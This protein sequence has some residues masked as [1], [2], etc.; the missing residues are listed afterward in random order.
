MAQQVPHAQQQQIS[1][2]VYQQAS[3]YQLGAPT[4]TYDVRYTTKAVTGSIAGF[5]L[6]VLFGVI[7]FG[8]FSTSSGVD[9]N[10][11]YVTLFFFA[12]A[13]IGL[14]IGIY[15]VFYPIIYRAWHVY[16]Y[17]YGLISTRGNNVQTFRWDHIQAVWQEVVNYYRYGRKTRTTHKYTVQRKDGF[18]IEFK[19]QYTNVERLGNTILAETSRIMLP[20]VIQ[21]YNSGQAVVFGPWTVSM[22]GLQKGSNLLPWH[23]VKNV[24]LKQGV[25]AISKQGKLLNWG[26]MS[27]KDLP[28]PL[29]FL[30]LID[31]ARRRG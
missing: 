20:A 21:A 15:Y 1:P 27:V 17:N 22:H 13:V 8:L 10:D 26:S 23:E 29:V 25:V 2:E 9:P 24:E 3:V 6:A 7:G 16:V 11:T 18:R 31:H 5:I 19:D 12:V 30:G 14:A 28:N 4:A